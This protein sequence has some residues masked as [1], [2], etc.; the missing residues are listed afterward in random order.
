MFGALVVCAA[1]AAATVSAPRAAETTAIAKPPILEAETSDVG[2]LTPTGPHRLLLGGAFGAGIKVINGDTARISVSKS[3]TLDISSDGR[4]AYVYNMQPAASVAV[5]DRVAR[6]TANVVE[7]PGCG[8][9]YPWGPS[10][11]ASLCA[12]GTLAYAS[13]ESGK[14]A[15]RL[16]SYRDCC[17]VGACGQCMCRSTERETPVYRPR[18]NNDI[19]WCF[20]TSSMEYHCSTAV[21]VGLAG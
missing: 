19:I 9:V 15:V 16:I 21:L 17:G 13:K 5:V 1:G 14:F 11:F 6:K 20:G 18:G 10:G 3:P 4:L 12:D 2:R 8:M 7:I